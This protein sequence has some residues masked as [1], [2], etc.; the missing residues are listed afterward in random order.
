MFDEEHD[1]SYK[2]KYIIERKSDRSIQKSRK[3]SKSSN[4]HKL[5][6]KR[7]A[8]DMALSS[9]SPT[10]TG[11][12][13]NKQYTETF[14]QIRSDENTT[15]RERKSYIVIEYS[16]AFVNNL[17]WYMILYYLT[18]ELSPE[19]HMIRHFIQLR[20][21]YICMAVVFMLCVIYQK[22]F[23]KY[24]DI[25]KSIGFVLYISIQ[26][27][28]YLGMLYYLLRISHDYTHEI[29]E[30]GVI[31]GLAYN[32]LS[33]NYM[34]TMI[35]LIIILNKILNTIFTNREKSD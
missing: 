5:V 29:Q 12:K 31:S 11:R 4:F 30:D 17:L 19:T 23:I 3:G 33:Y 1:Y 24:G 25:F 8:E 27:I 28:N 21:F 15:R 6:E 34:V 2:K 7:Y 18:T 13:K 14:L 26:C 35:L 9:L 16:V 20:I 22:Y 10:R 32:W